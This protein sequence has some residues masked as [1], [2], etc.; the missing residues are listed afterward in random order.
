MDEVG[1]QPKREGFKDRGRY[2]LFLDLKHAL[3]GKF[4][5]A[6]ARAFVEMLIAGLEKSLFKTGWHEFEPMKKRVA[7]TIR[8]VS[9]GPDFERMHIGDTPD[10]AEQLLKRLIQH[11]GR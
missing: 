4:D 3:G 11:Y 5:D 1:E 10:L 2:D 7:E 8:V 9:D 6:K